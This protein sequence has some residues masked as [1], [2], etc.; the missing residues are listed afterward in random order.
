VINTE[1][2]AGVA[3]AMATALGFPG[4]RYALV[5]HPVGSLSPEEVRGL[6][7][8]AAAQVLALLRGEA[9]GRDEP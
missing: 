5:A 1:P 7:K 8:V 2:L 3:D 4:Y 9:D 6:A